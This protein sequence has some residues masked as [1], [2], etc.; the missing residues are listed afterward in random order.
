MPV[1]NALTVF[2]LSRTYVA[3]TRSVAALLAGTTA[4][5]GG[6]VPPGLPSVQ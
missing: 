5:G 6:M 1:V 4:L 3:P 2:G